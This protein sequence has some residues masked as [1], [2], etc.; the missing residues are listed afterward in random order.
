M[1]AG[2]I[3]LTNS[4]V[5]KRYLDPQMIKTFLGGLGTSLRIAYDLIQPNISPM[6]PEN[7]IIIGAGPLVGTRIQAP[8]WTVLTKLPL[9]ETIGFNV[10]GAAFG[11]R[12]RSA[13][14]DHLIISGRA[15]KPVYIKICDDNIEICD[16]TH[17]W[18]KDIFESTEAL[19][20]RFGKAH[21]VV[22]IGQAGENLVKSS[23]ALIDKMSAIGKGGLAAVMGSKN[24]KAIV[25]SGTT[26]KIKIFNKE[27][28]DRACK[29]VLTR[30]ET[31]HKEKI[32]E[33]IDDF[34]PPT[35][36]K[37]YTEIYPGEKYQ[38]LYGTGACFTKTIG[39]GCI[40][41][42]YPCK[43]VLEVKDGELKGLSTNLS[44][45][46]RVWQL[47]MQCAGGCPS[48]NV[49]KLVDVA[50]RYGIDVQI[51]APTMEIL[52]EIYEKG[53]ISAKDMGYTIP[54]QDFVT[55]LLLLEMTAFKQGIGEILGD[56]T[57]GLIERFG[58][59]CEKFSTHNKGIDEVF[60]PRLNHFSPHAFAQVVSPGGR[61][62]G[63]LSC[64]RLTPNVKG[65]SLDKV[66]KY[67]EHME[68]P[69]EALDRIFGVPEGYNAARLTRYAEDFY[70]VLTS[71]GICHYRTDFYSWGNLA[72]LY[73]SATGIQTTGKELRECGE[74]LWNL[75]KAINV[76][77]GFNRKDDRFPDKWLEPLRT[78]EVRELQLTGCGGEV[79]TIDILNKMLNDYYDERGWKIRTGVPPK[80]KLVDLG[81][82]SIVTNH[83]N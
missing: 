76:R 32:R 55:T 42:A 71:L 73:S 39:K 50:Q 75:W 48:Q 61:H 58:K 7:V 83:D 44:S 26:R 37:N 2:Y 54:K 56:G 33:K 47:G 25:A 4:K 36:H 8:R 11:V 19:L 35:L 6:S 12:L 59:D 68:I 63:G 22:A 53:I 28:F 49:V 21:S 57:P 51:F 70:I 64:M 23:I 41:C 82:E 17:L 67:C 18:G 5:E 30:I 40:T 9:G 74:R 31:V 66:K 29:E 45:F 43:N 65:F 79:I 81:L 13:G 52:V 27:R 24:I 16:A 14:W 1:R 46:G 20:H 78:D 77:E 3:D 60:D 80:N 15:P 34:T 10:G 62:M 38:Q 69:N 72:E